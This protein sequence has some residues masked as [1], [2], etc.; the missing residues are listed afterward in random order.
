MRDVFLV[1]GIQRITNLGRVLQCL[2]ERQRP[3]EWNAL[4]VLHH[5]IIG[6]HV[7]EL[8][9]MRMIQRRDRTGLPLKT[10]A[11]LGL[12]N[13]N[14]DDAVESRVS[15]LVNLAHSARANRRKDLVGA[16]SASRCHFLKPACQFTT[17]VIGVAPLCSTGTGIRKRPSL[18]TS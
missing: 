12:R 11:E 9:N 2:I 15:R 16:E 5:Q 13:L 18:P 4:D 10:L 17:T 14:C 8:A 3:L 1:R 6:P 7:V